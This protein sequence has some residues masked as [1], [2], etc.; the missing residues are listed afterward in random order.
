MRQERAHAHAHAHEHVRCEHHSCAYSFIVRTAKLLQD[1]LLI[2][3][4]HYFVPPSCCSKRANL[5]T[6]DLGLV[7]IAALVPAAAMA[8][9]AADSAHAME[10]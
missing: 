9:A 1:R 10:Y 4:R 2:G 8:S 3:S 5:S 7:S 6:A